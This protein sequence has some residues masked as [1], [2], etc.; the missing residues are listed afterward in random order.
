MKIT[1]MASVFLVIS[2]VVGHNFALAKS[3]PVNSKWTLTES[4]DEI[5]KIYKSWA[6]SD[7]SYPT[8][9]MR[10]PY[11]DTRVFWGIGCD[12]TGS[13][14]VYLKFNSINSRAENVRARWDES[15]KNHNVSVE[16]DDVVHFSEGKELITLLQKSNKVIIGIELYGNGEVFFKW[17][18]KGSSKAIQDSLNNCR[19]HRK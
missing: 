5:S 18:L 14:W 3:F 11:E 13:K 16:S 10:S 4:L 15:Q 9:P 19:A 2:M 17:D 7:D 1:K 12:Q 8:R 6:I